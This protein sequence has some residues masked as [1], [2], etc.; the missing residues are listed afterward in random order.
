MLSTD[1]YTDRPLGTFYLNKGY[2][3]AKTDGK[4]PP[5]ILSPDQI[6]LSQGLI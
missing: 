1:R 4:L 2:K 6:P 5:K 3:P